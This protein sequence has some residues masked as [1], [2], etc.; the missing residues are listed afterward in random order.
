MSLEELTTVTSEG[1]SEHY[2][3]QE[4]GESKEAIQAAIAHIEKESKKA[5][6]TR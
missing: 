5:S 3:N 2:N 6:E 1:Q 4:I